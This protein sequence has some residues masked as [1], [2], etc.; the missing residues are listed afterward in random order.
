MKGAPAFLAFAF[1]AQKSDP[2][3]NPNYPFALGLCV[4]SM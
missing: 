4:M 1:T 2:T 3:G